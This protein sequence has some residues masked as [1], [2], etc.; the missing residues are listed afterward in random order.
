MLIH[1]LLVQS[2]STSVGGAICYSRR[3]Q[4]QHHTRTRRLAA[5]YYTTRAEFWTRGLLSIHKLSADA[6]VGYTRAD[7]CSP[8]SM[9]QTCEETMKRCRKGGESGKNGPHAAIVLAP[10]TLY[11]QHGCNSPRCRASLQAGRSPKTKSSRPREEESTMSGRDVRT[12]GSVAQVPGTCSRS[13][14]RRGSNHAP[15]RALL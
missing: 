2:Q 13:E 15:P 14:F 6:L 5:P 12:D 4:P 8:S 7:L 3:S 9:P 1:L 11:K 10:Q